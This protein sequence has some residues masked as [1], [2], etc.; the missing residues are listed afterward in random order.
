MKI[1][2]L[3]NSI[4]PSDSANSIHVMKMC[5]AFARAGH[6]VTLIARCHGAVLSAESLCSFYGVNTGFRI[7][8]LPVP[9]F[10]YGSSLFA[11]RKLKC[12]LKAY[13]TR[14]ALVVGRDIYGIC[15][16]LSSGFSAI[17]ETHAPSGRNVVRHVLEG[18]LLRQS[19]LLKCVTIS[20]ALNERYCK[21][22]RALAAKCEVHPDAADDD[23][24][25]LNPSNNVFSGHALQVG[26]V[27]KV[28]RGRGIDLIAEMARRLPDVSFHVVGG[29]RE[30]VVACAGAF[31][32]NMHCHGYIAPSE[33]GRYRAMC[34]VLLMPYQRKLE[35]TGRKVNTSRWMSPM[36]M[37]EYMAAGR[38]IVASDLPVLR[39][40]LDE[41]N[42]LLVPPDDVDAWVDAIN[43]LR[44]VDLRT[45]FGEAAR[46]KL[47][48]EY[49]WDERVERI[50]EGVTIVGDS[51]LSRAFL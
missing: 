22:Y 30:E 39:E 2:Y 10:R 51:T 37:F 6:D 45:Q 28:L 14:D 19:R 23:Y 12:L 13:S 20:Q 31:P 7:E 32:E 35:V 16:A 44:N 15:L 40:V 4:L 27:G 34:D 50:L 3:A 26:Y 46:R 21:A 1:I 5:A 17:Y 36:K 29:T 41:S 18:W 47:I 24:L 43:M 8:L 48:C 49:T 33:T 11:L 9:L 42:S 38:A 25:T